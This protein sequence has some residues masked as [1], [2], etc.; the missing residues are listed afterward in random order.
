[1]VQFEWPSSENDST[2]SILVQDVTSFTCKH[3]H[4][5]LNVSHPLSA[6]S[7]LFKLLHRADWCEDT[8]VLTS[9]SHHHRLPWFH[10]ATQLT[11]RLDASKN[12][13]RVSVIVIARER[14][15]DNLKRDGSR[16]VA[17]EVHGE[18]TDLLSET[19]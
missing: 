12:A 18:T 4:H 17:A 16:V 9:S 5:L 15:E 3:R 2:I 7:F 11:A 13:C 10:G 8:C 1:M 6:P 19:K 14:Y